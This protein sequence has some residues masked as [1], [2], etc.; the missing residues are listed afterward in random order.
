MGF[1][2]DAMPPRSFDNPVRAHEVRSALA[3]GVIIASILIGVIVGNA[4]LLLRTGSPT[5]YEIGL[6]L[7]VSGATVV[8]LFTWFTLRREDYDLKNE[9]RA[10]HNPS[11]RGGLPESQGVAS[12]ACHSIFVPPYH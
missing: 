3:V 7:L 9:E 5:S 1:Q 12:D 11:H 10:D 6:G 4:P 2:L 8:V